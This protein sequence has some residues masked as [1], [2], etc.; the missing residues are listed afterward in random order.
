MSRLPEDRG[1]WERLTDRLVANSRGGLRVYRNIA[2][3]WW[4]VLARLSLPLAVGAA[5]ALIVALF[6]RPESRAS[7][8]LYGF[9]PSDALAAPFLMSTTA[10][11]MAA[12][13]AT[14]TLERTQ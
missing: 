7:V 6:W 12:L 3:P 2:T 4:Q 1:Y 5:A 14:P 13:L 8:S 10:P 11:S 9:A